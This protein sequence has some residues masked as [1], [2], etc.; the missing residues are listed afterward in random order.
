MLVFRVKNFNKGFTLIELL[1]VVAI[2][3]VL[4]AI[5]LAS[6]NSAR[7]KGQI[8]K[9]KMELNQFI[10][11][12]VI[13]QGESGKN[14]IAITGSGCSECA[15]CRV[16]GDLRN[17]PTGNGCYTNWLND[18]TTIQNATGGMVSGLINM[19]RDSW[20]SPY[21]M[22]ENEDEGGPNCNLDSVRSVGPDGTWGTGDDLIY[23]IPRLRPC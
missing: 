11:A 23:S 21:T 16:F 3:G 18:I 1:V 10:K 17:V 5:V 6:L 9:A 12:A 13:A 14:L 2:I 4:A 8:A 19:T 15:V 22:D 20:G 7:L